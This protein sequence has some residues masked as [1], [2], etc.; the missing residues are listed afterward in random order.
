MNKTIL[1]RRLERIERLTRYAMHDKNT[2][3]IRQGFHLIKK[4]KDDLAVISTPII[5]H[6]NGYE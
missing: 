4:I 5:G 6:L 1:T 3:K 2:F